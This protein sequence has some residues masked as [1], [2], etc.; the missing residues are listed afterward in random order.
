MCVRMGAKWGGLELQ[1]SQPLHRKLFPSTDNCRLQH[2]HFKCTH[3]PHYIMY[4]FGAGATIT[5]LS[6]SSCACQ[7]ST[8]PTTM[9]T[10]FRL[11]S[12]ALNTAV[13]T[14]CSV[15]VHELNISNCI[16]VIGIH[17]VKKATIQIECLP[18][19]NMKVSIFI[20]SSPR[21]QKH[22]PTNKSPRSSETFSAL[23][24]YNKPT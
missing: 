13:V 1:V 22:S 7:P 14:G 15:R 5:S 3:T 16:A 4:P 19:E 2:T 18:M 17:F 10:L 21:Q 24:R 11:L 23:L 8:P 9:N 20:G 12:N 6:S